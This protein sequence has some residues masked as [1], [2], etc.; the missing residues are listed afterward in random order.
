MGLA[1][2]ILLSTLGA[3]A[4][5]NDQRCSVSPEIEPVAGSPVYPVLLDP[6]ADGLRMSQVALFH[7]HERHGHLRSGLSIQAREPFGEGTPAALID[8]LADLHRE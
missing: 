1:D 7:P 5:Q 4:E 2:V 8:V 3:T 6:T